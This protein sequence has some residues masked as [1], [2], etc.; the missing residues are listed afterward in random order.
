VISAIGGTAGVGKTALAVHWAHQVASRFGDGQLYVNLRGFVHADGPAAPAEAIRGFLY[1]LGVAPERIPPSLAAQTGLFRS[2]LAGKKML[3]VLDNARDEQQVRP[4]LPSGSGCLVVVTSRRHLAGLAAADGARLL[5]L[6]L[7]SHA[8]AR[9]M[10]T[11]RI[12]AT[13]AAAEPD[14]MDQIA[15]LCAGLPLALAVAAARANTR[16]RFS[17]TALAA[18]L[19]DN[20]SRLDALDAGDPA[21]SVRTVFSWS[22]QQLSP[23]TARIFRLLGLHPGTDITVPAAASLTAATLPAAGQALR[24]LTAANLLTEPVPGRYAFHDLLRAYAVDQASTADDEETRQ[25]ATGRMLDHYLHTAYAAALLLKPSR[26]PLILTPP[27]S[28]VT[29]EHLRDYQGALDWFEAEHKVLLA[30]LAIAAKS[31]FDAYVWQLPSAMVDFLD[32]RGYWHDS[33]AIQRTA[34]AAARRLGDT[35]GQAMVCRTLGT[36]CA[37]L[38]DFD[39][40]CTYM[41]DSLRLYRKLGDRGGQARVHQSLAWL[42]GCEGR[43]DD[44]LSHAVQALG[45]F[46]AIANRAGQ[47]AAFN[48]VGWCHATLGDPQRAIAF[49]RQALALNQELGLRR[50]EAHAWDS[51]GYVEHQLG[52]HSDATDCYQNALRLFRELGDRFNEAVI[53]TH[54]GDTHHADDDQQQARDAWQQALIILDDL[55]HPDADKVRA[56]LGR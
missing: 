34:L 15:S 38:T 39:Q 3:I 7:P 56:K 29:P 10:L 24:E 45:L 13:R 17:L 20:A 21:T 48:A 42:A 46:K 49:C 22:Y 35:A 18:E 40:A 1:A 26:E 12:G 31:G 28:G 30:A 2:L 36:A 50:D 16:P 33:A 54:L 25:A 43:R 23:E 47:A 44:A 51:V 41:T 11:L 19:S 14:A 5:S 8:E 55:R 6:D 4:L 52:H 9:Q 37:W 53:L 27:R 32:R